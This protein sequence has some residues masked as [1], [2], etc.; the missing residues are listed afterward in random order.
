LVV[1]N[2]GDENKRKLPRHVDGRIKVGMLPIKNFFI[3]LP[4][5][6][7]IIAIVI[8]NFSPLTLFLG[9]VV[10]GIT[11]GMFSEFNQRE[12]GFSMIKNIIKFSLIGDRHFERNTSYVKLHKR[13]IWNK[14][15]E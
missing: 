5:A 10:F 8:I 12:T 15:K 7:L 9:S 1:E 13:F 11:L 3:F 6:I 4:F 2:F 14:I